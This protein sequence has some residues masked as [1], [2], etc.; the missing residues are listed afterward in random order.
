LE[1]R[2][3]QGDMKDAHEQ[4]LREFLEERKQLS[5]ADILTVIRLMMSTPEYQVC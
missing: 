5:N 3:F 1:L 4:T 2:L